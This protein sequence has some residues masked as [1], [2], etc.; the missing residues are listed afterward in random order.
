MLEGYSIVKK[1][2]SINLEKL[3]EEIKSN[4]DEMQWA[5]YWVITNIDLAIKICE[6]S[7]INPDDLECKIE[8]ALNKKDYILYILLLLYKHIKSEN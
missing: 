1:D 4:P 6:A 7:Y 8:N 2:T 5:L 3:E